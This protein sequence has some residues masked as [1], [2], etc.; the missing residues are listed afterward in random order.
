MKKSQ[1]ITA[2][3]TNVVIVLVISKLATDSLNPI[4][5][6]EGDRLWLKILVGFFLLV[7]F[8]SF[9]SLLFAKGLQGVNCHKCGLPL[10]EYQSSHGNPVRCRLCGR[11]YHALCI[12]ADGGS[13][14]EGCKQSG[15]ASERPEY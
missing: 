11:W 6:F 1:V 14:M 3:I 4:E 2:I 10:L 7:I 5:V 12:K 8:L 13:M 9:A 15:C